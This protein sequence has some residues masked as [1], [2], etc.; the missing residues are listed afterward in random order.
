MEEITRDNANKAP[1][2]EQKR[3]KRGMIDFWLFAAILV[4][5]AFGVY[6]VLSTTYYSNLIKG[7]DPFSNFKSQ[8]LYA[9]IGLE[10]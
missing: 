8:A 5:L 9:G 6:M 10:I 7:L 1:L 3:K 4:L 2:K